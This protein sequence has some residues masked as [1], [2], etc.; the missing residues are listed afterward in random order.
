MQNL[1]IKAKF[2][3]LKYAEQIAI[4]IHAVKKW[5]R[6]QKDIYFITPKD[7]LKLRIVDDAVCDLIYYNR[8]ENKKAEISN[9]KIYKT[10]KPQELLEILTD[11]FSIDIIVEKTR[12]LYLYEN[13]RIHLDSVNQLGSFIEFEAVLDDKN[14]LNVS[15]DHLDFLS[16]KFNISDNQLVDTGYFELLKNK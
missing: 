2:S 9:Y 13:V 3:D 7:K 16:K 14:D 4:Q 6:K 1:E 5:T 11:I 8:P 10:Q 15:V 12:T